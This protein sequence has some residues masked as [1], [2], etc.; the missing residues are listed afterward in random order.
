MQQKMK[1]VTIEIEENGHPKQI[2]VMVP[3]TGEGG[4][5]D[6]SKM[7][8]VNNH[9][10]RVDAVA[11][12]TGRAKYAYDI[13]IP[14]MLYGRILR[15][16]HPRAR[17]KRIDAAKA[18]ALPGVKAV[19]LPNDAPNI[20]TR[21]GRY[22]GQEVAAVAATT[23]DIAEEAIQLIDVEYDILPFVV[24]EDAARDP[25]AARVHDDRGN[26][27]DPQVRE[28]GDIAAGFAAAEVT[29]EASY[30]T[31]VHTHSPLETHGSIAQWEGGQLTV[32]A[33]T[34]SIF[35]FRNELAEYFELPET[36]VRV[37]T[38]H[39]GGG[40]GAK[41]GGAKR[42]G[43]IC[44]LLARKTGAAVK[45]MLTRKEEHLT[46][47][48]RPSS[49]QNVKM[50]ATSD[51]KLVAYERYN[52]GTPGIAGSAGIPGGPYLYDI[53]N[54]KIE[55]VSVYTNGGPAAALRA[56]GHPQL[57][58]SME[59]AMDELAEKLNMDP[60][61]VRQMNDTHEVRRKMVDMGAEKIGWKTRRNNMPDTG[62]GN[63]KRGIGMG[64]CRWGGG[65]GRTKAHCI[66]NPDGSVEVRC[67]TQDIGTGTRTLIHMIAGE[68]FGLTPEDVNVRIGDTTYPFSGGSG[69]STTCASVS[70]AIK[71]TTLIAKMRLFEAVAP[72]FGVEASALE[73]RDGKV[74]V[75]DDP[76][77]S[78]TWKQ[79]TA[80]LQDGPIEINGQWVPG[81]SDSGVPGVQFAEVEVNTETGVVKVLKIVAVHNSGLI[82]NPLTWESQVNGGVL[83]GI[84]YGLYE[85]RIMD[86]AT[87]Y[88]VNANLE[89]YRL[90]GAMEI[91]EIEILRYDEPERGTIG[92]GEPPIIPTAGAIANAVYNACGARVRELPITPDKVLA[93]LA[94]VKEG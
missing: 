17:V 15:T 57:A 77:K 83:M 28:Q 51:G 22:A 74:F 39:M 61:D 47:G 80:Q 35:G 40:F 5:G 14:G 29:V 62:P 81:Y 79:A 24:D 58:F 19:L 11:K 13:K 9:R 6:V 72:R 3:D 46:T 71:S 44:A 32:W 50:G 59:S 64:S 68:E 21:E 88:M 49:I 37:I 31:Q 78:M 26:V 70:P 54:W 34:Q 60:L 36:K 90:I 75:R 69:G 82:I 16:A 67:G 84:G 23:Q 86:P 12:V 41:L 42:E 8:Y 56:P 55:Q 10:T 48:N 27:T 85:N 38:E 65:G 52:Y 33:S 20:F 7:Q 89:D 92:I 91:P 2:E 63:I 25:S 76:S 66:I 4:W 43:V 30:R 18:A 73:A 1:K 53:P 45:L 94:D 87:G 93:A